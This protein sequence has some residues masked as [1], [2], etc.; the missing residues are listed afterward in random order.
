MICRMDHLVILVQ[1]NV[2]PEHLPRFRELIEVN[3][4]ASV[5]DE[6][7][8]F[9]FDVAHDPAD[10]CKVMLY[11]IYRDAAAFDVHLAMPH[12]QYF[13]A[14]AKPLVERQVIARLTRT[15]APPVKA[16]D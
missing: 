16:G 5:R 10:P 11:E 8:C 14:Q 15:V 3:A 6:P 7:G 13:L 4:R 9:Q 1:F 12:T 2:K